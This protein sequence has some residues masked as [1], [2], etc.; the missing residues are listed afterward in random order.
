MWVFRVNKDMLFR[1]I[2]AWYHLLILYFQFVKTGFLLKYHLISFHW[3]ILLCNEQ[4]F[5]SNLMYLGSGWPTIL[6]F[7]FCHLNPVWSICLT[8]LHVISF[9][10]TKVYGDLESLIL[11]VRRQLWWS[12]SLVQYYLKSHAFG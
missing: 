10:H 11:R 2:K 6:F 12:F 3:Y 7:L 5:N 4:G 9:L 1:C 8:G